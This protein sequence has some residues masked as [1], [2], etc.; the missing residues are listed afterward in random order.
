MLFPHFLMRVYNG[1]PAPDRGA[2]ATGF[3]V[4]TR[5]GAAHAASRA[6]GFG[7][8]TTQAPSTKDPA[9]SNPRPGRLV[10][11]VASANPETVENRF[12]TSSAATGSAVISAGF[13]LARKA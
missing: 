10:K 4:G 9:P 3:H 7:A 1:C 13:E 6:L 11:P 8:L 12:S 5:L 2:L